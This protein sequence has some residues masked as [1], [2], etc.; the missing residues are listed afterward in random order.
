[1]NKHVFQPGPPDRQFSVFNAGVR[2]GIF[3]QRIVGA[4]CFSI[5]ESFPAPRPEVFNQVFRFVEPDELS[6]VDDSDAV[7]IIFE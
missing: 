6:L 5:E 3:P 1:M 7:G 2:F 4:K